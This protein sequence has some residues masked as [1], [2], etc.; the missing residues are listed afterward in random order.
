MV[1]T[2][3]G[4]TFIIIIIIRN[5][6]NSTENLFCPRDASG[7]FACPKDPTLPYPFEKDYTESDGE[8]YRW[9]VPGDP[10]GTCNSQGGS[11]TACM[12][13]VVFLAADTR[14]GGAVPICW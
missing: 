9:F 11:A 8:Q 14:L 13:R 12:T 1:L 3:V 6:W 10:T 5:V 7:A 2:L 4:A